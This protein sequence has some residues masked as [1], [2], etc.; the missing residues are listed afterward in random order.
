MCNLSP[1]PSAL[2]LWRDRSMCLLPHWSHLW[3]HACLTHT[4]AWHTRIP[5]RLE[6]GNAFAPCSHCLR[7]DYL[8]L[9]A[10]QQTPAGILARPLTQVERQGTSKCAAKFASPAQ[11][12][13]RCT[14]LQ[15]GYA[16]PTGRGR[17]DSR[18]ASVR[19]KSQPF[20]W[21]KCSPWML[22][23]FYLPGVLT[24]IQT[25]TEQNIL[26]LYSIVLF[27]K[28]NVIVLLKKSFLTWKTN[29]RDNLGW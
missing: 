13:T 15:R 16:S 29:F 20:L 11:W 3:T 14:A 19:G 10:T 17:G 2:S 6:G 26:A 23:D 5:D 12:D 27:V 25:A 22:S 9:Q 24:C 18:S 8:G 21:C 4:H 28:H 1:G 7:S